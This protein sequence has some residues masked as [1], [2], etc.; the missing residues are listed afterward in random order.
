MA[1]LYDV[2]AVSYFDGTEKVVRRLKKQIGNHE[3]QRIA[4]T[5]EGTNLY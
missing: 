4:K 1:L 3:K 5:C 2:S